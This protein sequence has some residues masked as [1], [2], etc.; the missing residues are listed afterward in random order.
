[1]YRFLRGV[2]LF[3][4]SLTKASFSLGVG[5]ARAIALEV[6]RGLI[7]YLVVLKVLNRESHL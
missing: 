7:T 1:M 5:V 3:L 2:S 4:W 6:F